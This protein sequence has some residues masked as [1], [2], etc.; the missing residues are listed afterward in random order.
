MD[1]VV[2]VETREGCVWSPSYGGSTLGRAMVSSVV[3][4]ARPPPWHTQPPV[5]WMPE[6]FSPGKC[7]RGLKLTSQL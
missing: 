7:V 5:Q 1:T 2:L 3:R 4:T 6:A